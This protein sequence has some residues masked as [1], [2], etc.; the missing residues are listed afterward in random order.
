MKA[1]PWPPSVWIS[2]R[3]WPAK[4]R[5]SP[6]PS[7][8]APPS[9]SPWQLTARIA[10]LQLLK[11]RRGKA[12]QQEDEM[13]GGG[14]SS[15]ERSPNCHHQPASQSRI[16]LMW[17]WQAWMPTLWKWRKRR[18]TTTTEVM[19]KMQ[20]LWIVHVLSAKS[21]LFLHTKSKLPGISFL[22][23]WPMI[24]WILEHWSD[25]F[26]IVISMWTVWLL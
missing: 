21:T 9:T 5:L 8:L 16:P 11:V 18:R 2:A 22:E 4:A 13:Q 3:R 17:P 19:R 20:F 14:R 26:C 24:I 6:S 7:P 15:W 1:P 10:R 23:K 25:P 12:L